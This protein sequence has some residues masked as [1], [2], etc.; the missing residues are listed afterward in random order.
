M[1]VIEF[2][3]Q[4][5]KALAESDEFQ[6]YQQAKQVLDQ[7]EAA[8]VMLDDFRKKQMEYERKKLNG[9]QL[10]QPYEEELRKLSAVIGLNPYIREYLMAEF[11]FSS[12]MMEVQK[13]I[14]KAVGLEMPELENGAGM[15]AP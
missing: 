7:H 3:K 4:L 15:N 13:I 12:L 1:R 6:K 5:G 10:L 9:D 2:A 14:G 11:Q 8:R